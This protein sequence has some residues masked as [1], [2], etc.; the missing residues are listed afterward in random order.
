MCKW[1][2]TEKVRV[3]IST[4]L[5]HT[6][7]ARWAEIDIDACISDI[8][9]ALQVQGI[10]MYSSCCGHGKGPGE[11]Q[12]QDGRVLSIIQKEER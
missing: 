6:G 9:F 12:L 7:K 8:V 5:S 3:K 2:T 10:D 11:I 4:A 1:G